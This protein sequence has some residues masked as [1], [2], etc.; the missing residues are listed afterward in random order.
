MCG[1][2]HTYLRFG[3][4]RSIAT[5]NEKKC[6]WN[7]MKKNREDSNFRKTISEIC[8]VPKDAAL[9]FPILTIVGKNEMLIENYGGILE[10]TTD[11]IRII[12]SIGQIQIKGKS[13]SVLYYSSDEMRVNGLLQSIEYTL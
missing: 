2:P 7:F 9:G 8:S 5:Y 4:N 1:E 3:M 11:F 12:T 13:L 10:Y 6:G